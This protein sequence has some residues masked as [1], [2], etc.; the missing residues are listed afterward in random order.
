MALFVLG[1]TVALRPF[2]RV[3]W[4][5]PGV[6]AIKLLIHPLLAFGLMLLFGLVRAAL[7]GDRGA[8]GLAAAGA[9]RVRDRPAERH[10]DR[11]GVGRAF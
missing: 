6:V 10:L 9:Q 8:D 3:P 11:A 5:V 7:G 4:E 1:V 2:K